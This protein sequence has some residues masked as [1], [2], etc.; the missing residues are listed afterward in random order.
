MV[1]VNT[2]HSDRRHI[3]HCL[4]ALTVMLEIQVDF[5]LKL[6]LLS[7]SWN[8]AL[9]TLTSIMLHTISQCQSL[10]TL[11]VLSIWPVTLRLQGSTIVCLWFPEYSLCSSFASH[12][13]DPFTVGHHLPASNGMLGW[14]LW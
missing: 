10:V 4:C 14:L 7:M 1:V 3:Y 9:L 12:P 5:E 11:S 13:L 6:V 2:E 8:K